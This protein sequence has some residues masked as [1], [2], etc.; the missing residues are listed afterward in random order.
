MQG[1]E[2]LLW[3]LVGVGLFVNVRYNQSS[4]ITT[5]LEIITLTEVLVNLEVLI[6]EKFIAYRTMIKN[7]GTLKSP[8]VRGC[9]LIGKLEPITGRV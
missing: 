7:L 1:F 4:Y 8:C 3:L 6:N 2:K 5:G 9:D